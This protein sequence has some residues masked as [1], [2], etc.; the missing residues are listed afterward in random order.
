MLT[1]LS[2][3]LTLLVVL[4]IIPA[5][6]SL[7]SNTDKTNDR[8]TPIPTSFVINT[9]PVLIITPTPFP[10]AF[11]QPTTAPQA[12]SPQVVTQPC[13][14][15]ASWIPYRVVAGDTLSGIARRSGTT[16]DQL[17]RGNCLSDPNDIEVGQTIYTPAVVATVMPYTTPACTLVPRLT[18][19]GQ[20]RVLTT[21]PNL[22]LSLPGTSTGVMV[23]EI[24]SGGVFTVLAGPQCAEGNYW[25]QVNYNGTVGW[26][27]EGQNNTYWLEPVTST[28]CSPTPRLTNTLGA[29]GRVTPGLP[30]KL[31]SLPS[32][33]SASTVIGQIPG[34]GVFN[35]VGGPQCAEGSYWWQVNYNGTVGWTAEGQGSTY[36]LEPVTATSS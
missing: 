5:A 12:T 11:V 26:T 33:S 10:T 14:I 2:A 13:T 3:K 15:P 31:R 16:T 21:T 19:G 4:L 34:G 29:V 1:R 8:P 28:T 17:T 24:P 22:L 27:Q 7:T 25:W 36:W 20:G 6:C 35:I 9:Q 32:T 23:G 18:V 30:N